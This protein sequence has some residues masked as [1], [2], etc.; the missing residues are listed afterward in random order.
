[1]LKYIYFSL[2][3]VL[4]SCSDFGKSG[5]LDSIEKM[6]KT[7]DS[8][9]IVLE[10]YPID[11]IEEISFDFAQNE[12]KIQLNLKSTDTINLDLGKKLDALKKIR[13][14]FRPLKEMNEKL[15]IDFKKELKVL[16]NLK[17]DITS[18]NGERV[19]Y[20]KNVEVEIKKVNEL[21]NL[22]LTYT[23]KREEAITVYNKYKIDLEQFAN[24]ISQN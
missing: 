9:S 8:L 4:Y 20:S 19:N 3:L 1:M 22:L 21:K 23:K 24:T 10:E 7:I 13:F 12:E 2:F 11:K 14:S 17:N 18:S 16:N 15:H 5:Q 6:T